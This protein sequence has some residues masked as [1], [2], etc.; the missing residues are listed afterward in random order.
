MAEEQMIEIVETALREIGA[1]E[2]VTAAGQFLP[3]GHTG[4]MFAGGL[5]G[6]S[7]AGS[8]GGVADS[9]AT[10][11][12]SLAGAHAH[13]AASGLPDKMLVGVTPTHVCG[14]GAAT[15]H[16][17]AGPFVFRVPRESLEVKVH[18]RVNVRVLEL[19]DTRTGSRIELEGNRIPL[20]H[21]KDV[22]DALAG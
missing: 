9:V 10:V 6:D 19:I 1:P 16:S 13:D 12:G 8:A 18:Q 21:S 7:L 2:E 4:S 11:G 20:T 15:R 14:F 3:R 17:P 22:I 5:V